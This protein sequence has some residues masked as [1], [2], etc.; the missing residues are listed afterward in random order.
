MNAEE[1]LKAAQDELERC[2]EQ[3][4]AARKDIAPNFEHIRPR[5]SCMRIRMSLIGVYNAIGQALNDGDR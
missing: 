4:D 1:L 2:I 3:L 5:N